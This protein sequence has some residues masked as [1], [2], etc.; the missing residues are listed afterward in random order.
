MAVTKTTP[1]D[2][3][4]LAECPLCHSPGTPF[5]RELYFQCSECK[6]FFRNSQAQL[7]P[8]REKYRYETHNNDVHNAG[9][10]A[11]VEP[12]TQAVLQHCSTEDLGL[13][14]GAGTGPVI[15]KL[16]TDKGYKI[17]QYDPYFFNHPELLAIKYDYIV[18]CEVME[19]FQNPDKE[20]ELLESLL[21]PGGKLF[22][23][24][25]LYTDNI[26]FK[27]WH[28]KN[29]KTHVFIYTPETIQW[30]NAHSGFKLQTIENRLIL[31]H[32][33]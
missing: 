3:R 15:S 13:D 12:I 32:R 11:F 28:Y 14:F 19:H 10:Q 29:D 16:L 1:N 5:F 18:C 27:N 7:S 9:Y 26:N 2:N 20:F 24:T 21:M 30:L 17:T 8:E 23:M 25:Q 22:C 31:F 4:K 33:R 6:G